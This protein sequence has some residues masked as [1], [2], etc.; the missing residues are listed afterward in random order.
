MNDHFLLIGLE[1]H[2]RIKELLEELVQP[3]IIRTC[4]ST[5]EARDIL[6]HHGA[7]FFFLDAGLGNEVCMEFLQWLL[8]YQPTYGA[9]IGN[10]LDPMLC[11]NALNS[12]IVLNTLVRPVYLTQW[13][14]TLYRYYDR[15]QKYHGEDLERQKSKKIHCYGRDC[16]LEDAATCY[17]SNIETHSESV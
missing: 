12:G 1:D 13:T 2:E 17:A 5:E 3:S 14:E 10:K 4:Q 8:E 16:A 7:D 11:V 6:E 9:I 15:Y